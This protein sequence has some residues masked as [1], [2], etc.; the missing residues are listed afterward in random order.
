MTAGRPS[1]KPNNLPEQVRAYLKECK[2]NFEDEV[3]SVKLP[4]ICG[5]SL[6]MGCSEKTIY[7]WAK[8]D[9]EFLQSLEDIKNE[10]KS[11]V[12]NEGL[13]GNYNS[14]IA[15]LILAANHGMSDKQELT[16][17]GGAPLAIRITEDDENI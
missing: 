1:D 9:P 11:R 13:S 14:T 6:K 2:D 7:N 10:Q 17:A 16:G 5:F 8:D 4:T 12:L 3:K 15:K